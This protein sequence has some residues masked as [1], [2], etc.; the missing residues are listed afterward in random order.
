MRRGRSR[1]SPAGIL[2]GLWGVFRGCGAVGDGLGSRIARDDCGAQAGV[3]AVVAQAGAGPGF[4][5]GSGRGQLGNS[6]TIKS[7][8][9]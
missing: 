6:F 3:D 2:A 5:M 8:H 7:A 9:F 1:F 4:G